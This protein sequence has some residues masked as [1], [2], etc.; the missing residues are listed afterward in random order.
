V[1]AVP[2]VPAVP[3]MPCSDDP[4]LDQVRR[5]LA[6][7]GIL[8]AG[9]N[10]ANFLIVTGHT[11]AGQPQGVSPDMAAEV[12]RRLGVEI[13]Y[14][15]YKTPSMLADALANDEWDMGLIGA[16]PQRAEKIAFSAPY[17]EIPATYLVR[18]GSSM[19]SISD[20][21]K[22]GVRISCMA[23]TAFDLWLQR[24][25]QHAQI[26]RAETMDAAFDLFQKRDVDVMAS[27]KQKLLDMGTVPGAAII[28]G[29]FMAVGQA[30]GVPRKSAAAAAFIANFVEEAKQTGLVARFMEAHGVT[31]RLQ[32]AP[33]AEVAT[34]EPKQKRQCVTRGDSMKIAVLGCGAMGSIY[35]AL[36]GSAGNEVW[37]VDVWKQHIEIIQKDG[38]R[39]EGASGDRTVKINATLDAAEVGSADMVII[40]TKASGVAAAAATAAQLVKED[41]AII[42]IQNGLGAGDRIAEHVDSKKVILGIAS[43]FGASMKGP[44]HAEHKSMNL[45]CLGEM[46]GGMTER[47]KRITD[48]WSEAGFT[49]KACANIHKNIWEKFICNCTYSGSA[50]LTGFT[51]GEVMDNPAAMNVALSCAREADAVARAKGIALDFDDVDEY[52]RKFGST[53]RTA[54]PSMLQDHLAKRRS[55]IDAINGAVPTEAAKV[56]LTAPINQTVADLIRARESTF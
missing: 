48:A 55:E 40:A 27:L 31:G 1:P 47:L 11:E 3:T 13:R 14:V 24:N 38:L 15:T 32:V 5:E 7:N 56:G 43:N 34:D 41:G 46:S 30:I 33:P 9:I 22:P 21:D 8:R 26:V 16:E 51:V 36:L 42:T 18:E 23:G 37:A 49:T 12:A 20:V 45:I 28:P 6:P 29:Q 4:S 44:G 50:T 39:V 53:V 52:V 54:R 2:A 10:L 17:V 35:A 25:I 19:K